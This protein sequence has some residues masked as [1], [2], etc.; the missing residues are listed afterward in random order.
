MYEYPNE[1]PNIKF[2]SMSMSTPKSLKCQGFDAANS[3]LKNHVFFIVDMHQKIK[4]S[5]SRMTLNM[6]KINSIYKSILHISYPKI[7]DKPDYKDIFIKWLF[8]TKNFF[9]LQTALEI[10]R[11]A[12]E[13]IFF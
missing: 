3:Q 2:V 8:F 5:G 13:L 12:I 7:N 10:A 11:V 9:L 4:L 6:K 1:L